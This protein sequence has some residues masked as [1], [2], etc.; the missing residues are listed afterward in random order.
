[1]ALKS[2]IVQAPGGLYYKTLRIRN[3]RKMARFRYK[4]VSFLLLVTNTPV[5]TRK[6]ARTNTLAHYGIRKLQ[7]CSV[8]MAQPNVIKLLTVAI[9]EFS[10][11]PLFFQPSLMLAGAP[12]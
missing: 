3:L 8:F 12:L 11:L 7:F 9:Y 5:W 10:L 6:L 4:L 2:F 1:M